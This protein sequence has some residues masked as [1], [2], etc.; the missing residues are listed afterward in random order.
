MSFSDHLP[1][2]SIHKQSSMFPLKKS[3]S[4]DCFFRPVTSMARNMSSIIERYRIISSSLA[5]AVSLLTTKLR[6]SRTAAVASEAVTFSRFFMEQPSFSE[7][8]FLSWLSSF[9]R[10]GYIKCFFY[11]LS[12]CHLFGSNKLVH[13]ACY[14]SMHVS[15]TCTLLVVNPC[16]CFL[17][18]MAVHTCQ[19]LKGVAYLN[20]LDYKPPWRLPC[21]CS[22]SLLYT[23]LLCSSGF[24]LVLPSK[25]I[26]SHLHCIDLLEYSFGKCLAN[27]HTTHAR[28]LGLRF[29]LRHRRFV[30]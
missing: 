12:L 30:P 10:S 28:Y 21:L 13:K 9:F 4:V 26:P 5:P 20:H 6:N 23:F 27:A 22:F 25:I 29:F 2:L 15:G 1:D 18:K 7:S 17:N 16:L 14:P 3:S 8:S 19:L 11:C 24:A